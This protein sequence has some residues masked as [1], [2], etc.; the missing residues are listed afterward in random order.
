[1]DFSLKELLEDTVALFA[2]Q[3]REQRVK[4]RLLW[5]PELADGFRGDVGK[6]QTVIRNYVSNALKYAFTGTI[7]IGVRKCADDS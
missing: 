5:S 2:V 3:A 4:L 6:I 7:D 1:V